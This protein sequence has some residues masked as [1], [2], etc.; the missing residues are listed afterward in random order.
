MM[1]AGSSS[2]WFLFYSLT[3]NHFHV[4]ILYHW[5]LTPLRQAWYC[6]NGSTR[7]AEQEDDQDS[8]SSL[9]DIKYQTSQGY[10][11]RLSKKA[12]KDSRQAGSQFMILKK[13]KIYVKKVWIQLIMQSHTEKNNFKWTV[14]DMCSKDKKIRKE[15]KLYLQALSARRLILKTG[16]DGAHL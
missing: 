15:I 11:A 3:L 16:H 1:K 14:S 6:C 9:S 5:K 10:I 13:S 2:T 4:N 12:G 8:D 7:E